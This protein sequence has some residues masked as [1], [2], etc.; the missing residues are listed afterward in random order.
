MSSLDCGNRDPG[1][2]D[3]LAPELPTDDGAR[4]QNRGLIF[5]AG[6][7]NVPVLAAWGEYRLRSAQA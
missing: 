7:D 1:C 6:T 2:A 3:T 5:I 4:A